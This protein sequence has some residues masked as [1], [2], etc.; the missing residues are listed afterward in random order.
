MRQQYL[1]CLLYQNPFIHKTRISFSSNPKMH[2][3]K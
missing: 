1:R 2:C 3:K